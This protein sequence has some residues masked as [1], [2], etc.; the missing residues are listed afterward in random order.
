MSCIAQPKSN[1]N[2]ALEAQSKPMNP[3]PRAEFVNI[4]NVFECNFE[5]YANF[6]NRERDLII[7]SQVTSNELMI[8]SEQSLRNIWLSSEEDEAWKGL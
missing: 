5:E 7:P 6:F 3:K 4:G 8:A 1:T 2:N